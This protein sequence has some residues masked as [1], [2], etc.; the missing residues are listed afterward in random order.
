MVWQPWGLEEYRAK[1]AWRRAWYRFLRTPLGLSFYWTMENWLPHHLLPRRA[2][3]GRKW[4]RFRF[5]RLL[6]LAFAAGLFVSLCALTRLAAGWSW[7]EP[8]GPL[9]VFLLALVLPYFLWTYLVGVVDLVHHTHP[10][11]I[12]FCHREE[13]DY[14]TATVRS[15]TH[16]LLPVGLN[17]LFHNILEH[18][19][20]HVDPR[21][22]LYNLPQAQQHLEAAYPTDVPVERLTPGYL[23]RILRTCRL[24]DYDKKQW[25][26]YDGRPTA[27]AQ[28]LSAV[29]SCPPATTPEER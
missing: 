2:D 17:Q 16:V 22:P 19:A 10:Q 8:V 1:P 25:L 13:W 27:P 23:L 4:S 21:I 28:H 5:D 20:H 15:T 18:T 7:A 26:D 3:L 9:G 12:W 11:A 24:Y 14:H 6:V 29:V